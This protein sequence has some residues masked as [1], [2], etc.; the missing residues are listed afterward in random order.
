MANYLLKWEG[1]KHAIVMG[2]KS[3]D[4]W[5]VAP[6]IEG[7]YDH[8]HPLFNISQFKSGFGGEDVE[9]LPQ[10]VKVFNPLAYRFYRFGLW[11]NRLMLIL[12]KF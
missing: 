10:F 11:V 9:F 6:K 4:Q 5:G 7:V 8:K 3:Y 12:K 2:K 1:I